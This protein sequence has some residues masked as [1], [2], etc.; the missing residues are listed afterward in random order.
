MLYEEAASL[1]PE[2]RDRRVAGT[3][4]I[5]SALP[6]ISQGDLKRTW[7]LS[8]EGLVLFREIRD[9]QGIGH[10]L[11]NLG[12]NAIMLHDYDGASKFSAGEPVSGQGG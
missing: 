6:A 3:L 7:V 4:L 11:N 1:G 2:V 10:S 5:F 12:L 9:V 8:E